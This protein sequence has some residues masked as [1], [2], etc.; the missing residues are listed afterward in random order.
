M[1]KIINSTYVSLDGV[2]AEP[3]EWSL[4]YFNDEAGAFASEMLYGAD[5]MLMGRRTYEGFAK[6]WTPRTGDF[7]DR[8]NSMPKYVASTTLSTLMWNNS[9]LIEGDLVSEVARIKER[10]NLIMYGYGPV[11]RALLEAGVLDE[12]RVWIHP[13]IVGRHGADG[14]LFHSGSAVKLDLADVRTFATGVIVA[15]YVPKHPSA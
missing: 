5:A 6:S 15:T 1:G 10:E 13:E 3:Q 12:L 2:Q 14:L 11:G 4:A 9:Q 7:A 8:F